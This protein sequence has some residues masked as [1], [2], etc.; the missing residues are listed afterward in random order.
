M[1]SPLTYAQ[2]ALASFCSEARKAAEAAREKTLKLGETKGYGSE[3]YGQSIRK[4]CDANELFTKSFL[5]QRS[6]ES[7]T[8]SQRKSGNSGT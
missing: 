7:H 3:E 5:A 6:L 2:I 1:S 8:A 4:S